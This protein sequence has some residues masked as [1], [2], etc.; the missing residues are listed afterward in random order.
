MGSGGIDLSANGE[1]LLFG[2]LPRVGED[3]GDVYVRRTDGS[4]PKR[5][6]AGGASALSPDGSLVLAEDSESHNL[7]PTGAGQPRQVSTHGVHT[8]SNEEASARFL[9]DMKRIVFGG[10]ETGHGR[11][12]W[13]QDLEGGKPIP[14][15]PENSSRG[16]LLGDGHYVCARGP[17]SI[18]YLYPTEPGE[19]RRV[20]GLLPGE[21]PFRSTPDGNGST[22]EAPTSSSRVRRL[23]TTRVYR[24]DPRTGERLLWKEIPSTESREGGAV[25][26]IQFSADGKTCVWT[27]WRYSAELVLVE[28]LK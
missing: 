25:T 21:E 2:D 7:V 22:S 28:G 6:A 5:L 10:F 1:T 14:V 23:M 9:P 19:P 17:D 13:I 27:Q 26:S 16:V 11:R 20:A 15:T 3:G 8:L 12:V 18:W 24:L 4:P